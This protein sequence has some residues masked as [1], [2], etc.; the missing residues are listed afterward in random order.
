MGIDISPLNYLGNQNTS[1]D[2]DKL[3]YDVKG[4][5]NGKILLTNVYKDLLLETNINVNDFSLLGNKFGTMSVTSQ[6]DRARKVVNIKANNNLGGVKMLD[7]NGYYDPS[8]KKANLSAQ[9]N[10]LTIGFL[11]PLLRV[12]ASGI[13]GTASG[14]VN[15]SVAQNN[16]VLT[17][18]VLAENATMKINYLQTRYKM[19]DSIR[20]DRKGI[21]FINV[22]VSDE[23]G[24]PVTVTGRVNHKNFKDFAADLTINTNESL[25]LN[26]KPKDNDLFYGTAYASGVTTIKSGNNLLSFD[27]S[28]RTGR[29]R[30]SLCL[31]TRDFLYPSIPLSPLS[32]PKP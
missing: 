11:N 24:N 4:L 29:I 32:T 23:K 30:N 18:A 3:S 15:L 14:K 7:I 27:I 28:A 8:T 5:L 1:N 19:T 25:V 16:I 12:F 6:F 2:P 31:L 13:T 22:K 21:K 17:G 20:F 9:A 10:K 26:T